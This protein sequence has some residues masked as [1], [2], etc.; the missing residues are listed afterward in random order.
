ML[1]HLQS[2]SYAIALQKSACDPQSTLKQ[3]ERK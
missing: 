1:S 2:Q 3:M